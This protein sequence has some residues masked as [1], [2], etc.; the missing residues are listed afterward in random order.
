MLM[1]QGDAAST[2]STVVRGENKEEVNV[3][4][5]SQEYSKEDKKSVILSLPKEENKIFLLR[6]EIKNTNDIKIEK[7]VSMEVFICMSREEKQ[8]FFARDRQ[9]NIASQSS[10]V[11]QNEEKKGEGC[12]TPSIKCVIQ[13]GDTQGQQAEGGLTPSVRTFLGSDGRRK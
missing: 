12:L 11:N 5:E 9:K 1:A 3:S 2:T 6:D 4:K 7:K 13:N 10:C 8:N